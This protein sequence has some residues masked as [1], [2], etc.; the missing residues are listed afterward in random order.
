MGETLQARQGDDIAV[1][2]VLRDPQGTN[3]SPYSFSNP[4]LMQ[5]GVNQPLNKPELDHVDLIG[6]KVTGKVSPTDTAKY[7]GLIGSPAATNPTAKILNTY[8]DADWK[9]LGHGW[10]VMSYRIENISADQYVRLR[11]TNLPAAVPFETDSLGNPLL[12]FGAQ[13]KIPCTDFACP[14]HMATDAAGAKTSSFD[15]AAWADLWFY[16]NP[17]FIDVTKRH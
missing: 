15:V 7:A 4:S 12:D 16:S 6:G 1:Y 3:N 9:N 5:I 2:I 11:G 8:F 14:S 17:I 10:K 13:Q